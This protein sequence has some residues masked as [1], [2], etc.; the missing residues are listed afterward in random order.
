MRRDTLALV[1]VASSAPTAVA[2]CA[3]SSGYSLYTSEHC[4][5][6]VSSDIE[7]EIGVRVE[8]LRCGKSFS[9]RWEAMKRLRLTDVPLS[10]WSKKRPSTSK[11]EPDVNLNVTK[12]VSRCRLGR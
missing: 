3:P 12:R 6:M 7:Y 10:M 11:S 2:C 1:R 5:S 4:P 8:Q 9:W